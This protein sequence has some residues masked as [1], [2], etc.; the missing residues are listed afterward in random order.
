MYKR[1]TDKIIPQSVGTDVRSA[2]RPAPRKRKLTISCSSSHRLQKERGPCPSCELPFNRSQAWGND[3]VSWK[4]PKN[5]SF[6]PWSLSKPKLLPTNLPIHM[7]WSC[8]ACKPT[9]ARW[10]I[11]KDETVILIS[12][13]YYQSLKDVAHCKLGHL[14]SI[15]HSFD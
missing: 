14:Y 6:F 12:H 7:V 3:F 2:S 13:V 15:S 11:R 9:L 4:C 10:I 8:I 5:K 1:A